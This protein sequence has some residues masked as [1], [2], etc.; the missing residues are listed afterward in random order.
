MKFKS[1]LALVLALLMLLSCASCGEPD[2]PLLEGADDPALTKGANLRIMSYN[3]LAELWND[4]ASQT[5]PGR[6][7]LFLDVI[8][9]YQPDVIGLQEVSRKWHRLLNPLIEGEYAWAGET[10]PNTTI[11][12]YSTILYNVKTVELIECGTTIYTT[13]DLPEARNLT[14]ARFKHKKSKK[15]FIV[16]STHW[17]IYE[18]DRIENQPENVTLINELFEK[19]NLPIFATGDYNSNEEALFKPFLEGTGMVD[20]KF[21]AE[22]VNRA[23][24]TTHK[25]TQ[26]LAND[27]GLAIDHIA[28]TKGVRILYYNVLICPTT[29]NASDHFPVYIDVK[30]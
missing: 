6:E 14:W 12:N 16:T 15:E 28:V 11:P 21:N 25:L 30:I 18:E 27:T 29:I 22:I 13:C 23:T 5:L 2:R 8:H 26:P 24:K 3:I 17:G 10:L 9:S 1:I 20:P 4:L 7:E 19:Y